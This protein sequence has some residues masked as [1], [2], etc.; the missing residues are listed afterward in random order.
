VNQIRRKLIENN[1][2]KSR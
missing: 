1:N 2:H